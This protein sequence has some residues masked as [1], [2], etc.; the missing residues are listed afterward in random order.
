[1]GNVVIAFL[2]KLYFATK[3][4]TVF[5]LLQ[6]VFFIVIRDVH[7]QMILD[8]TLKLLLLDY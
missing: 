2:K 4:K 8:F 1:M 6:S 7:F 3:V 5:K